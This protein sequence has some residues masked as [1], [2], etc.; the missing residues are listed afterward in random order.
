MG[1]TKGRPVNYLPGHNSLRGKPLSKESRDKISRSIRQ[2]YLYGKTFDYLKAIEIS[3]RVQRFQNG[4]KSGGRTFWSCL[5][6]CGNKVSV[7]QDKLTSGRQRSCGCKKRS[8]LSEKNMRHGQSR[9]KFISKDESPEYRC[10]CKIKDRCFNPS[11]PGWRYYG[12]RGITVWHGWI[13][14]FESFFKHIGKRPGPSYSIDRINND[15]NYAPGNVR[16]ATKSEQ[17]LN[18]RPR[19]DSVLISLSGS[20]RPQT[21]TT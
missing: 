5:C 9:Q 11:V 7:D 2:V 21:Q 3:H 18:R 19:G 14:S 8:I 13:N 10:W 17:A 16:W 15:G 4:K 12:G 6:V 1:H 20:S